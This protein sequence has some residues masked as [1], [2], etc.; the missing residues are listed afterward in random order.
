MKNLRPVEHVQIRLRAVV[1][2]GEG[3]R[4][5]G[6]WSAVG[7]ACTACD[8]TSTPQN[9]RMKDEASTSGNAASR[10][11]T[12]EWD[13]PAHLNGSAVS[14]YVIY[15]LRWAFDFFKVLSRI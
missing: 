9:L 5:E 8:V 11:V 10:H 4:H 14:E 6:E 12:L 13:A 1:L 15:S 3:K 2:D 7:F